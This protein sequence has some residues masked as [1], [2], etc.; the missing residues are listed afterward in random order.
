MNDWRIGKFLLVILS[1][2][3]ALLGS[4]GIENIGLHI[5]L[6]RQ[7]IGFIYL[8]FIPGIIILRILKLHDL[9]SLETLL[10]AVGLSL[11]TLML[12]GLLLNTLY[13]L[14]GLS[15]PISLINLLITISGVVIILCVICYKR[16]SDFFADN[17]INLKD[18]LS[19]PALFLYL[20]PFF[21]ILGTYSVNYKKSNFL[22]MFMIVLIALIVFFI[23]FDIFI[24]KKL[25]SLAVYLISFSLL[26]H[27]ALISDYIWGWDIHFEYYYSNLVLKNSLWNSTIYGNV[28]AMLSIVMLAP[29]YSIITGLSLTWVL[30]IIYPLIFSLVPLGIYRIF[31]KQIGDKIGFL[32]VF[33]CISFFTFYTEM[34]A[35]A[36]QQIA[37]LFLILIILLIIDKKMIK[38]KRSMLYIIFSF[39]IIVS[40]YGI[41]YI[42]MVLLIFVWSLFYLFTKY[43]SK[44]IKGDINSKFV[45][46]YVILTLAWYMYISNSSALSTIVHIGSQISDSVYSDFLDPVSVEPINQKERLESTSIILKQTISPL[47]EM[48]KYI[49]LISQFFIVVGIVAILLKRSKIKFENEY[50]AFSFGNLLI[51]LASL[52][53]PY[54]ASSLNTTRLYQITLIFLAPFAVIGGII[55]FNMISKIV[56][57]SW[58]ERPDRSS[59]KI[60][61]IF[62]TIYFLFNSGFV[63]EITKDNPESISLSQETIKNYGNVEIKANFYTSFIPEQDYFSAIWLSKNRNNKMNVNMDLSRKN[64]LLVS[65]GNQGLYSI[66]SKSPSKIFRG[67][68]IYT[69]YLNNVDKIMVGP[70]YK[71][72]WYISEISPFLDK[73]NKI[74]TN[75]ASIIYKKRGY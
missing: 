25:Y 34:L 15:R 38:M 24:P 8:T 44:E 19:L 58:N 53:I 67:S 48:G 74:Y 9:D 61:F 64:N 39:S 71:R 13:P 46:L 56:M 50:I 7:L 37:E 12:S 68:Y 27:N 52:S 69:G 41:S 31:Q 73:S 5:P 35:L 40:H 33:F 26:F 6:L 47:H 72:Y 10:Y 63:Y 60:M 55:I 51:L 17:L 59:I 54:F 3:L 21:T 45:L 2:Q 1:V 36:R 70:K 62:F 29:I 14:F 75:N 4:I 65:Y 42:F 32:S 30:K 20:L 57:R 66:L 16:D 22:L 18:V 49:H 23:G 43:R 28:N 11:A